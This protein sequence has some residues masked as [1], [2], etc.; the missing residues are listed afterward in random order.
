MDKRFISADELLLDAFK[1]AKSI[2]E[3]GF[4]PDI[5]AGV[6]RGGSPIAIAIHEY[7]DFHGL[8]TQHCALKTSSYTDI[9]QQRKH[10]TI[11]GLENLLGLLSPTKSVLI[12]DD[13]F[14]SGRSLD[15]LIK[16]IKREKPEFNE[17]TIKIACPW[18]KPTCNTTDLAPDF[19]LHTTEHWLVF[20]HELMHLSDEEIKAGKGP[21][22]AELLNFTQANKP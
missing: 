4:I 17:G 7:L 6:W 2:I 18:Y 20:P 5:I 16:A 8:N 11:E 15:A 12:V 14:D 3:A 13:V 1:L 9:G 19:Y 10:I 22:I 21:H